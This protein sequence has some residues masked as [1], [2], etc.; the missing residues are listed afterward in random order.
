[1]VA[2]PI[3]S[4]LYFGDKLYPIS[5]TTN[6]APAVVG[7]ERFERIIHML[8]TNIPSMLIALTIYLVIW[9]YYDSNKTDIE[10]VHALSAS[11]NEQHNITS[12]LL[13]TPISIL[14]LIAFKIPPLQAILVG[15]L[16][17]GIF[18]VWIQVITTRK[19]ITTIRYGYVSGA[20]N[21]Q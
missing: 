21:L 15:D 11:L 19:L 3:V 14:V 12:L 20:G 7:S 1:M 13:V 10:K 16:F 9:L 5:E 6:L 4:G 17:G 18:G 2:G 8:C